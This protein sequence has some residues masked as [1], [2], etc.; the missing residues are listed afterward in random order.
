MINIG[1]LDYEWQ[2]KEAMKSL[3]KFVKSFELSQI[4]LEY[5][6][7][8]YVCPEANK[9]LFQCISDDAEASIEKFYNECLDY[10]SEIFE[11][12]ESDLKILLGKLTH[13]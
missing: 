5:K 9:E 2:L 11:K 4:G 10:I 8:N 7:M 3:T 13:Y 6:V 1:D 12:G